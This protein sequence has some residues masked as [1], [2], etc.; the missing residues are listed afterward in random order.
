MAGSWSGS[1]CACLAVFAPCQPRRLFCCQGGCL[2]VAN[3]KASERP[4][5]NAAPADVS[6]LRSVPNRLHTRL[7]GNFG[8]TG[9]GSASG[10]STRLFPTRPIRL[11]REWR[12]HSGQYRQRWRQC[13][14]LRPNTKWAHHFHKILQQSRVPV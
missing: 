4:S 8:Q 13:L 14:H 12:M 3:G 9:I 6:R 7:L 2:R 11:P 10:E 1:H 5:S